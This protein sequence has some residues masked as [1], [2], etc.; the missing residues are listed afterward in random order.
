M[1]PLDHYDP[2]HFTLTA[3]SL[4]ERVVQVGRS[5]RWKWP[6]IVA[7]GEGRGPLVRVEIRPPGACQPEEPSGVLAAGTANIQVRLGELEQQSRQTGDRREPPGP[8]HSSGSV[9][10]P[11][12]GSF[13]R[14]ATTIKEKIKA[15]PNGKPLSAGSGAGGPSQHPNTGGVP[16][17][18]STEEGLLASGGLTHLE[19]GMYALLGVS[20]LAVLLLLIHCVSSAYKQHRG[21]VEHPGRTPHAPD[22]VWLGEDGQH[23][24]ADLSG[25]LED[26]CQLLNGAVTRANNGSSGKMESLNSPTS[27]RNRVEFTTFSNAKS[28]SGCPGLGPAALVQTTDMKRAPSDT[29]LRLEAPEEGGGPG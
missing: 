16:R 12:T 29:E 22:W 1:T 20:C 17:S 19:M 14:L 23:Q 6:T 25:P 26:G 9:P 21:Q 13:R 18:R 4:E 11:D 15:I 7:T 28:W 3:T 10:E 27:R 5:A 2:A 24:Q 8:P